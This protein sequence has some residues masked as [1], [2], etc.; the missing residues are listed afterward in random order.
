[1]KTIETESKMFIPAD[2]TRNYYKLTKEKHDELIQ[3]HITK[4]YKKCSKRTV[5]NITKNDKKM[6]TKL[7]LDDRIYKTKEKQAFIQLKDHKPSFNNNP[8]CRLLNPT[9]SDIGKIA[10]K[11]LA[12][13]VKTVR[14]KTKLLQWKNTD[15]VIEWFENIQEKKRKVFLQFDICEFYP[16]I[17]EELLHNSINFASG[18][19]KISDEDKDII[20]QS[21]KSLLYDKSCPWSKRGDSD[22]DISMGSFH[23]VEACELVG[24]FILSKLFHL[25]LNLGLY[26]DDAL[27]VCQLT[28]RQVEI[29]KMY[30]IVVVEAAQEKLA[31]SL[32]FPAATTKQ[33]H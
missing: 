24:L 8:T 21:S 33:W 9:K 25:N 10:K 6:A 13:I 23:G 7:E 16:S 12:N 17:T 18:Y 26:R 28:P 2:K 5:Q 3:K 27:G 20:V 19:V 29:K 22:F 15:S 30:V 32:V 4:D 11:K 31:G 14:E 1:M